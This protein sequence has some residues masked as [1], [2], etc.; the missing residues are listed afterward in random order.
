MKL[1]W[2]LPSVAPVKISLDKGCCYC[3]VC[4]VHT[5]GFRVITNRK[6]ISLGLQQHPCCKEYGQVFMSGPFLRHF[7]QAASALLSAVS[8]HSAK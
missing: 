4:N 3:H 2:I 8:H 6:D 1:V 7:K 5:E